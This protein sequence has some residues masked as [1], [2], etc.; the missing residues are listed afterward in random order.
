MIA[1]V[2]KPKIF[3]RE[4]GFNSEFLD[5]LY[6]KTNERRVLRLQE[7]SADL[8]AGG[9][10][11]KRKELT[12]DED[13]AI[14]RAKYEKYLRQE[15]TRQ[16]IAKA[17]SILLISGIQ[18]YKNIYSYFLIPDDES[19]EARGSKFASCRMEKSKFLFVIR[20]LDADI[21]YIMELLK[22]NTNRLYTP[23]TDQSPDETMVKCKI[24]GNPHH[25]YIP[26]KI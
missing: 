12:T 23:S 2:L 16:Q 22:N 10:G 9:R 15:I 20:N 21:D 26:G 7:Y 25:L 4:S 24:C 14:H 18:K 11:R 17:F 5:H 6:E 13:Y 1:T 8:E 3:L 19:N